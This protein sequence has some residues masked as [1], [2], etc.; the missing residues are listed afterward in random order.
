MDGIPSPNAESQQ[1]WGNIYSWKSMLLI[2]SWHLLWEYT[3]R[4]FYK[5]RKPWWMTSYSSQHMVKL[6]GLAGFFVYSATS[7]EF[8]DRCAWPVFILYGASKWHNSKEYALCWEITCLNPDD[9]SVICR[10]PSKRAKLSRWEGWCYSLFLSMW[11][12]LTN[13]G[14]L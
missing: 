3:G 13:H 12:T 2:W 1:N 11:A 8:E 6:F 5:S 4:S 14:H 7:E 10:W 9:A